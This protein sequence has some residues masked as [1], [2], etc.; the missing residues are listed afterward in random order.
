MLDHDCRAAY[1]AG[2]IQLAHLLLGVLAGRITGAG[3]ET[4]V[5]PG[6]QHHIRAAK[7]ALHALRH[8]FRRA[9]LLRI[10]CLLGRRQGL[11][12]PAFGVIGAGGKLAVAPVFDDHLTAALFAHHVGLLHGDL[13]TVGGKLFLRD[14]Q[15]PV[16]LFPKAL[17]D[18]L[19]GVGSLFHGVQF[20]LH[21]CGEA[22]VHHTAEVFLHQVCG[23]L[24]QRRR[25]QGLAVPHDVGS[26]GNGGDNGRPGTGA[27]DA[28][29]LQK[30]DQ[31]RLGKARRRLGKVP[32][33]GDCLARQ[34]GALLQ[35][36]QADFLFVVRILCRALV[37][38]LLVQ[39]HIARERHGITA[40][41]EHMRM[42]G[43]FNLQH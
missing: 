41:T 19:C 15:L 35:I 25:H 33:R 24:S 20:I 21:L 29:F 16:K 22:V 42:A 9:F 7:L 27:P 40:R 12:I 2:N 5:P 31:R 18:V 1:R 43:R 36:R 11:G 37:H 14:N 3:I 13:N 10:L 23:N 38:R 4:A 6:A 28:L 26:L 30:F 32:V 39:C 34:H 17:Q 8:R